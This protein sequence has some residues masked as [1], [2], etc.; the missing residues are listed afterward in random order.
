MICRQRP[1]ARECKT[2]AAEGLERRAMLSTTLSGT[3][4]SAAGYGL[5]GVTVYLDRNNDSKIDNGELSTTTGAGSFEFFDVPAGSFIV[6]QVLPAGGTQVSPGLGYGIHVT[7]GNTP[8]TNEKFV[9]QNADSTL[10][11]NVYNDVDG[12]GKFSTG[13]GPLVGVTAYLDLN[14]NGKLDSNEPTSITNSDSA[15]N[16]RNLNAGSY[17]VRVIRP[18]GFSQVSPADNYG[19]HVTLADG[20]RVYTS[21]FFLRQSAVADFTN[22][23]WVTKAPGPIVRS[24]ALRAAVNGKLYVFGGFGPGNDGPELRSDV[25]DPSTDSWS[26]IANLPERITHAGVAVYGTDV[27]IVGGYVGFAGQTGY[28]QTFGSRNVWIYHTATNSYSAGPALPA[29]YAGGGAVIVNSTLHYFG[30]FDINRN[31]LNVHVAIDLDNPNPSW[32]T[33]AS[34]PHVVNHMGYVNFDNK[35]YAIDGQTGTDAGLVTQD[36]VQVYDPTTDTW[37]SGA[38]CP[39][40]RSHISSSTFVMGDRILFLGGEY[41]NERESADCYAYTPSTNSWAQLTS[42][43]A[44]KFS[45]VGATFN[46]L[47]YLTSGGESNTTYQGTPLG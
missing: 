22:V 34:M 16:F 32:Y 7:V 9:D 10:A 27:Y 39:V 4:V 20:Q 29:Q 36:Y 21:N 42:L 30:G 3:V 41:E 11:G 38:S 17:I 46:G 28:G 45:G 13:D 43:P 12:N 6:R 15:Y 8:I 19:Q 1:P 44:A 23:N 25:Y 37:T 2:A 33:R 35:I 26:Q 5:S 24:E 14:N 18:D 40:A 31:D 47:L